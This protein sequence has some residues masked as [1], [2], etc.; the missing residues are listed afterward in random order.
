MGLSALSGLPAFKKRPNLVDPEV[1][2]GDGKALG[3]EP[4]GGRKIGDEPHEPEKVVSSVS[5]TAV[6]R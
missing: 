5:S 4:G 3:H 6:W 2:Y 1:R